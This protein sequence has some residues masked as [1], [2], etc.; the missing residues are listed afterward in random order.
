[1]LS[2]KSFQSVSWSLL[3]FFS[4]VNLRLQVVR[5]P[6]S[7]K[8][9]RIG[10]VRTFLWLPTAI[11]AMLVPIVTPLG[12]SLHSSLC[13]HGIPQCPPCSLGFD[14]KGAAVHTHLCCAWVL[15]PA[16]SNTLYL[17]QNSSQDNL[18]FPSRSASSA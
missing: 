7:L 11:S 12:I 13:C 18:V 9:L 14:E 16:E 6:V 1:M 17:M 4:M 3:L 8:R 5:L 10:I 15:K 2:S